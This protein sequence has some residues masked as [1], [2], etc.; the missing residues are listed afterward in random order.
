MNPS[1]LLIN[2]SLLPLSY[3]PRKRAGEKVKERSHFSQ[4]VETGGTSELPH[5]SFLNTLLEIDTITKTT[6]NGLRRH[7]LGL[8]AFEQFLDS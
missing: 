4:G 5:N 8:R 7:R 2:H 1:R 3:L 6:L